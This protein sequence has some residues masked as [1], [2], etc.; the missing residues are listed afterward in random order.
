MHCCT[1]PVA[2]VVLTGLHCRSAHLIT[3]GDVDGFPEG[4]WLCS[5]LHRALEAVEE[6]LCFQECQRLLVGICLGGLLAGACP[7][8][9]LM[10]DAAL[11]CLDS[12]EGHFADKAFAA[13]IRPSWLDVKGGRLALAVVAEVLNLL[14]RSECHGCRC[15][16]IR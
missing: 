7:L 8:T 13:S 3:E 16:P 1:V 9:V 11:F 12:M 5:A 4:H 15:Q 2:V 6:P 14:S 10:L